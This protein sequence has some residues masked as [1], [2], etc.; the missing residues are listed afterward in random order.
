[1][2]MLSIVITIEITI[3]I[4]DAVELSELSLVIDF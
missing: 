1:M 2:P 4:A 3:A